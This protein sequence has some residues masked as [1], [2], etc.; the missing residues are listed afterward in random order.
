MCAC[1]PRGY[2]ISANFHLSRYKDTLGPLYRGFHYLEVKMYWYNR[3][4]DEYVDLY[5]IERCSL[6]GVSFIRGSTVHQGTLTP[7]N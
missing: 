5:F 1:T 4:W 2:T 3:N 7:N 6:F